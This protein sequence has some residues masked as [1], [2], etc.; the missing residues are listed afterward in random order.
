[1]SSDSSATTAS[2]TSC[3]STS[4]GGTLKTASQTDGVSVSYEYNDGSVV[5][6]SA[7]I[8]NIGEAALIAV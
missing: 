1:M 8:W 4:T 3:G 2:S 5:V 6:A 7:S